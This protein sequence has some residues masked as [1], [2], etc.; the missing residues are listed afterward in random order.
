VIDKVCSSQHPIST[1]PFLE[2]CSPKMARGL[3]PQPT[4]PAACRPGRTIRRSH[5]CETGKRAHGHPRTTPGLSVERPA[6]GPA[7]GRAGGLGEAETEVVVPVVGGVPVAVRRAEVPRFV[8][9]GATADHTP[10]AITSITL[11][12]F[13]R[14]TGTVF[15]VCNDGLT[16]FLSTFL[17]LFRVSDDLD[18][19]GAIVGDGLAQGCLQLFRFFNPDT[20][21]AATLGEIREARVVE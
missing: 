11:S 8:V 17:N 4:S 9:P 6:P 21:A 14:F 15:F 2:K 20:Q 18:Q 3:R 16:H 13:S 5:P 7:K 10:A 12:P 19:C 1:P